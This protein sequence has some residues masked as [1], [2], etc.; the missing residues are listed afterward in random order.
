VASSTQT[1]TPPKSSGKVCK[2]KRSPLQVRVQRRH[3]GWIMHRIAF[4]W[5]R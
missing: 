2:L 5:S 4:P 3:L 1:A